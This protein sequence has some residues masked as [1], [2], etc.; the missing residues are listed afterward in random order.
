MRLLLPQ[1]LWW[2]VP[3]DAEVALLAFGLPSGAAVALVLA[4]ATPLRPS[5]ASGLV[6]AREGMERPL[7]GGEEDEESKNDDRAALLG[8][9]IPRG[10]GQAPALGVRAKA[11]KAVSA[12]WP[13][14]LSFALALCTHV[15]L[16]RYLRHV[17]I[18]GEQE[19]CAVWSGVLPEDFAKFDIEDLQ[20]LAHTIRK[21]APFA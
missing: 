7:T 1:T 9:T 6:H 15:E 8:A 13:K 20:K 5:T 3:L 21:N 16:I 10:Q 2:P 12:V 19:V 17:I 14:C 4:Q 11:S 18:P